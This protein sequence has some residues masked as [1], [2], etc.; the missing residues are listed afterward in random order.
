MLGE[1]LMFIGGVFSLIGSIGLHRFPDVY[2][3]SHAQTVIN[4]GGTLSILCGI[5]IQTFFS[6]LSIK[7]IFLAIL[8]FLTS[9]VG[10]HAIA[11]AAYLS[12]I[13]PKVKKDEWGKSK[14][15]K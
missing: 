7:A 6:S 4:V 3:R 9:P 10:T 15:I 5:I 14:N 8:I 1:I 2:S 11:K 13:K 12:G